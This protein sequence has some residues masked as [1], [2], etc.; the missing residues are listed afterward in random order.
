MNSLLLILGY[1]FNQLKYYLFLNKANLYELNF[2][3]KY[4]YL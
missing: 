1:K 4:E 2:K 3:D